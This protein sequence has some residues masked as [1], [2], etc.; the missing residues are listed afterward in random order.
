MHQ[1]AFFLVHLSS[2]SA[3]S[4]PGHPYILCWKWQDGMMLPVKYFSIGTTVINLLV[5][6]VY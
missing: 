5:L 6:L 3:K 1:E 4:K 2:E